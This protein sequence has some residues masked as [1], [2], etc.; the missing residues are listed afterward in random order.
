MPQAIKAEE[1][2]MGVWENLVILI[3]LLQMIAATAVASMAQARQALSS[4]LARALKSRAC[5]LDEAPIGSREQP[6]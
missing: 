1:A 6:L 5:E 4:C 2:G 3:S